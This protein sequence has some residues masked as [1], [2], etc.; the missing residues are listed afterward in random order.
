VQFYSKKLRFSFSNKC[1]ANCF[2]QGTVAPRVASRAL[3]A[4]GV[5]ATRR[6]RPRA[7][8]GVH[9]PRR[10]TPRLLGVLAG[11]AS[12]AA[13]YR[14]G[15][16]ADRRSVGGIPPYA[17]RSRRS[18]YGSISGV[19]AMSPGAHSSRRLPHCSPSAAI[20]SHHRNLCSARRRRRASRL[21]LSLAHTRHPQPVHRP[22]R[23]A[24]SPESV[25]QRRCRPPRP[26][27]GAALLPFLATN[28]SVVSPHPLPPLLPS[29]APPEPPDFGE[30]AAPW[31]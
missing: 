16:T 25:L 28:G 10:R 4:L 19:T 23:A 7:V 18:Y 29:R 14:P 8:R 15:L 5:R 31:V 11:L 27:A 26:L 21:T 9:S 6:P 17:R 3:P 1:S 2:G 20:R 24:Q 22:T 30:P 13:S 12:R